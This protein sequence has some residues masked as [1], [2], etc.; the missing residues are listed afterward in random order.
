VRSGVLRGALTL[1]AV[2]LGG[3]LVAC[4]VWI[5]GGPGSLS[6]TPRIGWLYTCAFLAVPLELATRPAAEG[7]EALTGA[8]RVA[9]GAGTVAVLWISW[10]GGREHGAGAALLAGAVAAAGIAIGSWVFGSVVGISVD[11]PRNPIVGDVDVRP[12]VVAS[13]AIT[14][15]LTGGAGLAGAAASRRGPVGI[16]VDGGVRMFVAGA[17]AAVAFTLSLAATRPDATAAYVRAITSA[18]AAGTVAAAGHHLLVLPDQAVWTLAAGSGAC[19]R[20]ATDQVTIDLLCPGTIPDGLTLD[21]LTPGAGAPPAPRPAPWELMLLPVVPLVGSVLG[22]RHAGRRAATSPVAA[23]AAAGVVFGVLLGAASW[24]T[25]LTLSGPLL[26]GA[27]GTV[28]YGPDP[29]LA[30]VFG[31]IWG[32]VGGAAG[33]WLSRREPRA[34]D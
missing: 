19:V 3:Q 17:V 5:G 26:A 9:F 33:G 32:V 4:A 13:F 25:A 22:G 7:A 1:G 30:L 18:G 21:L 12:E 20:V 15:L 34:K 6:A 16:S 23:G 27:D 2:V 29:W 14:A 11:L 10:R 8:I 24:V 28:R 31:S